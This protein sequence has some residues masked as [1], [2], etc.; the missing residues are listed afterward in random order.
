[1]FKLVQST[2]IKT[3]LAQKAVEIVTG[4]EADTG[5][6]LPYIA[7]GSIYG[8]RTPQHAS[9]VEA[10]IEDSRGWGVRLERLS[11]AE[12]PLSASFLS[13]KNML[14]ACFVADDI[15]IEEPRT[16][17]MA[18]RQAGARL[19]MQTIGHTPVTGIEIR[20][21]RVAG[22]QTEH[23]H[24]AT[25]L[26]IDAAGAWAR[27]VARMALVDVPLQAIR[28]HVRISSPI[29]GVAAT[30][31]MV[32]LIDS[33][34]Y[35]RPARGGLM[36]GGMEHNPLPFDVSNRPGFGIDNLPLD[37][38]C[39]DQFTDALKADVPGLDGA[40]V[41][42]ER[43]GLFTMTPD[44]MLL[45]GPAPGVEGFWMA[46][47]CNGTGFSLSSAVGYY[48]AEWITTGSPSIDMAQVNPG[49]FAGQSF[50]PEE[51]AAN[52]VWQYANYYTPR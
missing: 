31:P 44:G 40:F 14:A 15:Y 7:S 29:Q 1:M 10:E 5:V 9:M 11:Q 20:N 26:T 3:R 21:G 49:R 52:A 6:P 39:N 22:V 38:T 35:L 27:K 32:R 23:G 37:H 46:T 17:L 33:A 48:L 34:A 16:L 51:L 41:Q 12:I 4:F 45:A 28:H 25:E 30:E 13:G 24:I 8:A 36:Y 42:E 19:G 18:Y 50:T 43:G 2:E 47:G